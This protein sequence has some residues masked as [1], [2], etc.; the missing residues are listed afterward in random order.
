MCG[1]AFITPT[2]FASYMNFP[3]VKPTDWFYEDVENMVLWDV[4][5]GNSDGT[6]KPGNYINR[7]ELSVMWNRYNDYLKTQFEPKANTSF[8]PTKQP[9]TKTLTF[10]TNSKMKCYP[11]TKRFWNGEV[12]SD[13]EPTVWVIYDPARKEASRCDTNGCDKYSVTA[14]LDG[15]SLNIRRSN[16]TGWDVFIDAIDA[17]YIERAT[18][19]NTSYMS[20]GVCE[21]I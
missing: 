5:R 2:I 12:W 13:M 15:S 6:F 18:L 11:E 8:Q 4:I 1:I 14:T 3:D 17:T 16:E 21:N 20:E 19:L 7:A 10:D 9:I